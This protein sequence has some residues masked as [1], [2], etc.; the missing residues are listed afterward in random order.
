MYHRIATGNKA[1]AKELRDFVMSELKSRKDFDYDKTIEEYGNRYNKDKTKDIAFLEEEIVADSMFDVFNEK[2][3]KRLVKEHRTLAQRIKAVIDDFIDFITGKSKDFT[4][5]SKHFDEKALQKISDMFFEALESTNESTKK[6]N[7]VSEKAD[8]EV[9]MSI[10]E[11]YVGDVRDWFDNT[12]PEQRIKDGGYFNVGMTS[13]A[14]ESI[15]VVNK[16]IRYYKSKIQKVLNKHSEMTPYLIEKIP[17]IMEN[18]IIIMDSL[19]EKTSVIFYGEVVAENG[20]PVMVSLKIN[21]KDKYNEVRDYDVITNSFGKNNPQYLLN[22]SH[23]RFI[24]KK[25]V[26]EWLTSLRLQL[27]SDLVSINS[28]TT[29]SQKDKGVNNSM[30]K[31]GA[32]ITDDTVKFSK[33]ET[34]SDNNTLSQAQAEFF[35][36]SRARDEKG[37]LQKVY[38]STDSKDFNVFD[39]AMQGRTDNGIWGRGF[40]FDV[41]KE[42]SKEFGENTREFYLNIKNPYIVKSYNEKARRTGDLFIKNGYGIDFTYKNMQILDFIKQFGSRRFSNVLN[43]LGYDGL[44]AGGQELVTFEPNQAKLCDNV[45]PSESVDLRFSRNEDYDI[46]TQKGD[47]DNG[48]KEEFINRKSL[49]SI[50]EVRFSKNSKYDEFATLTMQWAY[51]ADTKVGDLAIFNRKGK[52]FV[53]LKATNN[54][55]IEIASGSYKKVRSVYE[56]TYRGTA[57]RFYE[58]SQGIESRQRDDIWTVFAAGDRGYD[59]GDGG[60]NESERLQADGSGDSEH[61]RRGNRGTRGG[62]ESELRKSLNDTKTVDELI[63][64]NARL[65]EALSLAKQELTLTQGHKLNEKQ[66]KSLATGILR[67]TSSSYSLDTLSKNL[68]KVFEYI[69]ND[70]QPSFDIA[71]DAIAD[72]SKAVISE[73]GMYN[74]TLYN[75]YADM[76]KYFRETNIKLSDTAKEEITDYNDFRR[77]NFGRINLKNDGTELDV[78]WGEISEMYPEFFPADAH[79][80]EQILLIEDALDTVNP[81]YEN[82]FGYD[83]DEAAYDLAAD[84]Y[85]KYFNIAEIH[86]FADKKKAQMT[87]LRAEYNQKLRDKHIADRNDYQNRLKEARA[88]YQKR[89]KNIRTY[90][91][92]KIKE[93][94]AAN[95]T[96][97]IAARNRR[98]E[99]D[100]KQRLRRQVIKKTKRLT[101]MLVKP[102][103]KKHIPENLKSAVLEFSKSM[104]ETGI[105]TFERMARLQDAYNAVEQTINSNKDYDLY[106]FYD[107][108]ISESIT[109]LKETLNNRRLSELDLS[110]LASLKNI[111]ENINNMVS[112]ENKLFCESK[113]QSVEE[114]GQAAI[115]ELELKGKVK[116]LD[117]LNNKA[118][119]GA[120]NVLIYGNM[121]P[122]YFFK[123]LGGTMQEMFKSIEKAEDIYARSINSSHE[124]FKKIAD[125]YNYVDWCDNSEHTKKKIEFKTERG[126][127]IKMTAEEA[128]SL[129]A[130]IKRKQGVEHLKA[131]G[132]K[133]YHDEITTEKKLKVIPVKYVEKQTEAI[134]LTVNDMQEVSS[135]LSEDQK[136]F[137]DE[138]IKYLSTD[139]AALGNEVSLKL[140]G[141]KKFNETNY[142]PITSANEYLGNKKASIESDARIKHKSFT[143]TTVPGAN[144][145]VM[146]SPFFQMPGYPLFAVFCNRILRRLYDHK[147][148]RYAAFALFQHKF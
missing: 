22:T 84:I 145:P 146:I 31:S 1:A 143:N 37:R 100:N 21:P 95:A 72:I 138:M 17:E 61:L 73:S 24:D 116:R 126:K 101:N 43:A 15:G 60:Q 41:N 6:N 83:T 51:S 132:F 68:T 106:S 28:D 110:E 71:I 36:D 120:K 67:K 29:L 135:L 18:P 103:E 140:Y 117:I 50:D 102:T 62:K 69:A 104:T 107:N 142:F 115:D 76:R 144:N 112:N 125:K 56:Q 148:G 32:D 147:Q 12:T 58:H 130:T 54:G 63:K 34:D 81:Y 82:P 86:T 16:E 8:G 85:D 2:S 13:K 27:P 30:K 74:K 59:A 122:V 4:S 136:G 33:N 44:I 131:G 118:A 119:V 98:I 19:T 87:R 35:E 141:Y 23:I 97:R 38:H 96:R 105:F 80:A 123:Y 88:T 93:I 3:V 94:Q 92:V 113:K 124:Y 91:N 109:E 49:N 40:Y 53:L 139:M 9:K 134:Q 108:G 47:V 11:S 45:K 57:N 75:Q 70:K 26:N 7:T 46:M 127:T 48:R 137:A 42:Y 10:N 20:K 25:R 77:R 89:L 55:S 121:K 52:E 111:V 129:Y 128:M 39:K 5:L 99:T 66:I 90:N 114:N 79:E 133:F 78:L 64:E 65:R 14:L